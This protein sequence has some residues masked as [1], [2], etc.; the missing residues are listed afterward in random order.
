MTSGRRSG[1]RRENQRRTP[2][3]HG[4]PV[5]VG[6]R[7]GQETELVRGRPLRARWTDESHWDPRE[8]LSFRGERSLAGW[9]RCRSGRTRYQG[10]TQREGSRHVRY[11]PRQTPGQTLTVRVS[12]TAYLRTTHVPYTTRGPSL[13][14][15]PSHP[16]FRPRYRP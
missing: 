11:C 3:G 9:S 1:R 8:Y 2:K 6:D 14:A 12:L 13:P 16:P 7:H 4:P 5:G 15:S 10:G